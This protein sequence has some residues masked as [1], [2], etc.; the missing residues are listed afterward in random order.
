MI[1]N[2]AIFA[3]ITVAG[4][5]F[6]AFMEC[7]F[8]VPWRPLILGTLRPPAVGKYLPYIL[9][10]LLILYLNLGFLFW[11]LS[12]KFFLRDTG[13]KLQHARK[14]IASGDLSPELTKELAKL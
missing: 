8:L 3:G 11:H 13:A 9:G 1:L 6:W 2:A 14:Q 12:R 4:F 10:Y 7:P 5:V